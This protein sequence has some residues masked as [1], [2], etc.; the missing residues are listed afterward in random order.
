MVRV[1]VQ[2][3]EAICLGDKVCSQGKENQG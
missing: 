2:E 3:C 1:L